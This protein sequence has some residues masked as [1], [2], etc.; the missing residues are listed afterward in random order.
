MKPG[1]APDLAGRSVP[2]QK[3]H[4]QDL[5]EVRRDTQDLVNARL[6]I[7]TRRDAWLSGRLEKVDDIFSSFEA[8]KDGYVRCVD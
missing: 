4:G 1:S 7:F 2:L 6:D 8:T 5:S 3:D